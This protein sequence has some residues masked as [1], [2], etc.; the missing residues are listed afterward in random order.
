M[1]VLAYARV[2][3]P[4][5]SV[6]SASQML[7]VTHQLVPVL[8]ATTYQAIPVQPVTPY[9]LAVHPALVTLVLQILA[10]QDQIL[11]NAHVTVV[12]I[13]WVVSVYLEI[14]YVLAILMTL[15]ANLVKKMQEVILLTVPV[16]QDI[17][18][19]QAVVL[20]AVLFV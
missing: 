5:V 10:Y 19:P 1:P 20:L 14:L 13:R 8:R 9:V 6:F 11:S 3:I 7:V 16:N 15:A 12:I 17:M 2:A 4:Q 18:N